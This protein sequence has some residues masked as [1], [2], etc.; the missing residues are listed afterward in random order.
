ML[1]NNAYNS[2]KQRSLFVV[3]INVE[4]KRT[5]PVNIT[6]YIDGRKV[7]KKYPVP[8]NIIV[9]IDCSEVEKKISCYLF[10]SVY[11]TLSHHIFPTVSLGLNLCTI[12]AKKN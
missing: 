9:Y 4:K 5:L 11:Y 8:V 12:T 1:S 3:G 7:E 6:V 2:S 10:R